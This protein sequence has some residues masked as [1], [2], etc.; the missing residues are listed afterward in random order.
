MRYFS[1]ALIALLCVMPAPARQLEGGCGTTRE[2]ARQSLFLHRQI[3]R[4]LAPRMLAAP[5]AADSDSGN[6][7]IIQ[8]SDGVVDRLNQFNLDS[9][10]VTF[11]PS[12]ANAAQYRYASASAGYDAGAAANGTALPGLGDDDA[13]LLSLPFPFPFFGA[14][15]REVYLNSDGNLTFTTADTASTARSLGRMTAGPPRISPLF[16]DLDPSAAPGSVHVLSDPTR[17][18]VSWVN[19]PEYSAAGSGAKQ[20]FQVR[21]YPDGRIEFSYNGVTSGIASA[22]VGIAPGNLATGTQLVDF[23]NDPT[24]SYAAAVA[25]VFANALDIDIVTAAQ[26]FYAEH[27]DAYDYLVVYNNMD[28]PAGTAGAVAYTAVVRSSGS[29]YGMPARDLGQ[30][31]GSAS[32]LKAVLDMGPL[33]QYPVDPNAVVPAR[34]PQGDT[35]ISVLA[36]E[37]GHLFLAY[38]SIEG[39]GMLGFQ[40]AHWSF[41]YDSEAS[42]LEGERIVDRGA[43][44]SGQFLTTDTVQ[45]YSP[46]DQYLMGFRPASAVPDTF[47]VTNPKPN[48]PATQHPLRGVAFNGT[49]ENV[50]MNDLT[51]AVGT[52]LP[53]STVAQRHYR[54]GFILVT[55]PG[56]VPAPADL[57]Q[58]DTY[59][60]QFEAFYAQ[61][62]S[63]LAAADTLL[64]HRLD[65]SLAPA[66]GVV[67]GASGT[68]TLSVAAPP[69]TN[70]AIQLSAP[71]GFVRLPA[72]VTIP[73]GSTSASFS[74]TGQRAGVEDIQATPA[75]SGYETAYARIAVADGS[76]LRLVQVSGPPA[77]GPVTV[78]LTDTNNLPYPGARILAQASAGGSVWPAAATADA[79]GIATFQWMPGSASANELHLSVDPLPAVALDIHAGSADPSISAVVSAASFTPSITAGALE[80]IFGANLAGGQ[81]AQSSYPWPISLGGVGVKLNSTSVQ[82]LYVSDTQINF[83]VPSSSPQGQV[84]LTVTTPSGASVSTNLTMATLAPGIFPGAILKAGT[85]INATTTG[86]HPG[87]YIE[88]YCTGLGQLLPGQGLS[89]TLYYPIAYIGSFGTLPL[90]SGLAPGY[91]GLY[92]V[93]AQVPIGIPAGSYNVVLASGLTRS[94][95]VAIQVH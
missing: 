65:L 79:Q 34:T 30:Q 16:D 58:L 71:A 56:T 91:V 8:A 20:T 51:E 70:L 40:N 69:A 67:Q 41:L 22:V 46:L 35:P 92:Q 55:A 83:Y 75:D 9:N 6:I 84:T 13:E 38:A 36:H 25:E 80:T 59:R 48:Y 10:T 39:G 42:L 63:N 94:N 27:E 90:Y 21:L 82:L 18:V 85:T 77:P 1:T 47:L 24:A 72:S 45:G 64:Q 86:V 44:T 60:R 68:A 31:Y 11:S 50:V 26:R 4:H 76:A 2:T 78:R 5:R 28:I 57:A 43:G 62:A 73:A 53:D 33:S 29:G 54:F 14:V 12:G 49:R 19:V 17:V 81:I 87:D 89:Q 3:R 88:I 61:A 66:A 15:Y 32:R 52:R 7:A 93:D 74:F 95:A 37:A 23:R